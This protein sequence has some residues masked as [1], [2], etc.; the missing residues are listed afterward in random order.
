MHLCFRMHLLPILIVFLLGT[1]NFV[2]ADEI[3][4][5]VASFEDRTHEYYF[6]LIK[7]ALKADGHLLKIQVLEG[8]SQPRIIIL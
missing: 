6:E 5:K 8:L 1:V 2:R 4:L 7:K 3:R